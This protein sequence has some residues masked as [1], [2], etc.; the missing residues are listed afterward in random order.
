MLQVTA[1]R[2]D[3]MD[4]SSGEVLKY[5]VCLWS[6]GNASRDITRQIFEQLLGADGFRAPRPEMQKLP[7]DNYMR[8]V[9]VQNAYAAGD[10][11]RIVTA[12]LPPTAQVRP[13]GHA[14]CIC[15]W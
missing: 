9:G 1:V 13:P 15:G 4:L 5:G 10:C 8:I 12:P 7:V 6:A 11:S 3:E 2:D 14:C